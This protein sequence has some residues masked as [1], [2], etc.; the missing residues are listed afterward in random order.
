MHNSYF[1][2]MLNSIDK[3]FKKLA[4]LG[5]LEPFLFENELKKFSFWDILHD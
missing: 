4:S 3:L 1:M 2:K 5:L